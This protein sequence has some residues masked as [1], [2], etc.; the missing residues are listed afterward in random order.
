MDDKVLV[1][2]AGDEKKNIKA[3]GKTREMGS[4]QFNEWGKNNGWKLK[5]STGKTGNSETTGKNDSEN[6]NETDDGNT[7]GGT[8]Q[9]LSKD[10]STKLA[11]P[12][13]K[14]LG[15]KEK[16]DELSAYIEGDERST[17]V[18]AANKFLTAK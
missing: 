7:G 2:H 15:E 6:T 3:T 5:P 14:D 11:V 9:E 18:N 1:F 4:V 12:I 10:T 8:V 16:L 13:I 17:I